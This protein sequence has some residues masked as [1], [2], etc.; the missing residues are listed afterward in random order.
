MTDQPGFYDAVHAVEYAYPI[1]VNVS[2][3][4]LK[5]VPSPILPITTL[6]EVITL[7]KIDIPP[8][9]YLKLKQ[10]KAVKFNA[11]VS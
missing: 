1:L 5:P 8:R 10:S 2:P 9:T 3:P 11:K 7:L 6:N 4:V